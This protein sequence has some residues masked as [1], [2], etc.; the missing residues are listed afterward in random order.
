MRIPRKLEQSLPFASKPKLDS[1]KKEKG[2]KI[3]K[4][5]LPRA[6]IMDKDEKRAY[7]LMQQINTMR[8]EK[9]RVKL[10][11]DTERRQKYEK[12]K[13]RVAAIFAP[14]KKEEKK[15]KYARDGMEEERKRRKIVHNNKTRGEE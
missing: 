4:D 12:K 14:M 5:E 15:R 13:E 3:I 8:K 2:N 1:K 10:I 7:T 11:K 9:M 6:L